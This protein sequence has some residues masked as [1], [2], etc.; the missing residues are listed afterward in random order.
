MALFSVFLASS[1]RF[2]QS[3]GQHDFPNLMRNQEIDTLPSSAPP[4]TCQN[5]I[6]PFLPTKQ[7][8]MS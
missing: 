1:V 8:K 3:A 7:L 5:H 4:S 6:F 2:S